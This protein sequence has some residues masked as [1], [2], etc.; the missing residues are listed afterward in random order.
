MRIRKKNSEHGIESLAKTHCIQES[1]F[2]IAAVISVFLKNEA[3][4][5][6]Q[7]GEM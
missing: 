2:L 5:T 6:K 7:S 3:A 1:A 4:D